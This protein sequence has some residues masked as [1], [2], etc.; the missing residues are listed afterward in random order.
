MLHIPTVGLR[1]TRFYQEIAKEGRQEG[2]ATLIS[3]TLNPQ[4]G[5]PLPGS[6]RSDSKPLSSPIGRP[7]RGAV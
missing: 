3:K 1:E 7:R 2:E 4:I 6:N 5:N